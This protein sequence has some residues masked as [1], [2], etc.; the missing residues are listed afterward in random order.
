MSRIFSVIQI[1][2]TAITRLRTVVAWSSIM[3]SG[4]GIYRIDYFALKGYHINDERPPT[5]Y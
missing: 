5:G 3:H 2:D 1:T 4:V